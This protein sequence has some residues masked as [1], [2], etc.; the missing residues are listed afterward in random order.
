[1]LLSKIKKVFRPRKKI[2]IVVQRQLMSPVSPIFHIVSTVNSQK[3]LPSKVIVE[4][5][6]KVKIKK[7]P[8]VK[9]QSKFLK[10][11]KILSFIHSSSLKR[12]TTK[13][14]KISFKNH[15]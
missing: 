3:I 1:M 6:E 10:R 12:K 9:N 14:I 11:S 7:K 5:S 2:E 8:K 15:F 13:I 4:K